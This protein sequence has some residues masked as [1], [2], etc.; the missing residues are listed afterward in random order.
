M[1]ARLLRRSLTVF[2]IIAFSVLQPGVQFGRAAPGGEIALATGL[3]QR[4]PEIGGLWQQA[5][6]NWGSKGRPIAIV[7]AG[8]ALTVTNEWNEVWTGTLSGT[9]LQ[10][11]TDH[12]TNG[13]T[14]DEGG[15]VKE[16]LGNCGTRIDMDRGAIWTRTPPGPCSVGAT[17]TAAGTPKVWT[18]NRAGTENP[19]RY[20][21]GDPIRI[22]FYQPQVGA[23][24]LADVF[25]DGTRID[26]YYT[27]GGSVGSQCFDDSIVGPNGQE[28][29]VMTF[30]SA[31]TGDVSQA[32]TCWED[33]P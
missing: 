33:V 2:A 27:Y 21:Q 11:H 14:G 29:I 13:G 32:Q 7:Q 20:A 6:D 24:S 28:C 22:C 31:L 10:L 30:T 9:R 5:S 23:V 8:A 17:P 19:P 15:D 25:A 18:V 1:F 3:A 12:L 16:L 26:P 4:L